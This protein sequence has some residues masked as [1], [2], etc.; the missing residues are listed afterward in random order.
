MLATN[1]DPDKYYYSKYGIS[2]DV[3]G[4]ISRPN[5]GFGKN[6]VIFVADMSSSCVC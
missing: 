2:F 4:N 3:C 1:C 5:G 6:V